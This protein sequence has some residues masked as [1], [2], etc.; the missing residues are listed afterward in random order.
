MALPVARR[1][2]VTCK[3]CRE[4][5]ADDAPVIEDMDGS[6][7][8]QDCHDERL[9]EQTECAGVADEGR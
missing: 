6:N 2:P 7:A 8:C 1:L 5:I 9:E 3:Y 4:V